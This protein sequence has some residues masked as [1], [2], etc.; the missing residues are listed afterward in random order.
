MR[1]DQGNLMALFSLLI[2]SL[3]FASGAV[4]VFGLS[5]AL[6]AVLINVG[7]AVLYSAASQALAPKAPRQQVQAVLNQDIAPRVRAYGQVKLGGVRA[8]WEAKNGTLQQI[9]VCHQG[10]LS[11]VL[12]WEVDGQPVVVSGTGLVTTDPFVGYLRIFANI[13]GG[14]GGDW[15][16]VR[17]AHPTLWTTDHD[18]VGLSTYLVEMPSPPLARLSKIFPQQAQTL[19]QM[20][21]RGSPVLDVRTGTVG[22]SDNPALAA[23]DYLTHAEGMRLPAALIDDVSVAALANICDGQVPSRGGGTHRRYRLGGYYTL[24]DEPKNTLARILATCD[25]QVYQTPEGK[26]GFIGGAWSEPDVTITDDDILEMSLT[27]GIDPFTDFNI[28]KGEY[29]DP[30]NGYQATECAAL[31]DEAALLTQP[32][33]VD[34]L[35][36][37]M[38]PDHRQMQRLLKIARAKRQPRFTATL[39]TNLV[40]LKARFPKGDGIHTIRVQFGTLNIDMVFEVLAHVYSVADRRCT[41]Q[42]R[43]VEN[44]YLWDAET[45]EGAAPAL[46]SAIAVPSRVVPP[47]AGL[48]LSQESLVLDQNSRG[49]RVIAEVSAPATLGLQLELQIKPTIS[50]TWAAM[51]VAPDDLR[52]YSAFLEDGVQYDVRARWLGEESWSAVQQITVVANPTVPA[53]PT[54]L[55][56]AFLPPNVTLTWTNAVSGYWRTRVYRATTSDINDAVLITP[57]SVSGVAGQ[58]NS[59]AD[60]PPTGATYWYW[61]RTVNASLVPSVATGPVIQVVP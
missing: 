44:P 48:A 3:P 60:T 35:Q 26:I 28:L 30:A 17:A 7:K 54:A 5:P 10:A 56:H 31:R 21:A 51:I 12:G 18:L 9:V 11:Q 43:S 38:V 49:A 23:R 46:V 27:D 16:A 59:Y 33:R 45:E 42:I 37:D 53:A 19:V 22:Y 2:A 39:V 40:G 15:A 13:S 41:L 61:V 6:S 20:I 32:A 50:G 4:T 25:A 36:V 47:P 57:D 24:S 14:T 34:V 58:P 52:G 55:S 8:F 29:V 1:L